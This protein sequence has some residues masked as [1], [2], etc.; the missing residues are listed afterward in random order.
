MIYPTDAENPATHN[1]SAAY[2]GKPS[3]DSATLEVTIDGKKYP[4]SYKL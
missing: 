1:I 2:K 3:A 4:L